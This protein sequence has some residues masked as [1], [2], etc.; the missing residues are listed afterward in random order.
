MVNADISLTPFRGPDHG[1]WRIA[2]CRNELE[3]G[4]SM[5]ATYQL[6]A[7]IAA[8]LANMAKEV[9]SLFTLAHTQM[10]FTNFLL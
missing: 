6:E 2:A 1:A 4:D 5:E 10:A 8:T 7:R 9:Q 3:R